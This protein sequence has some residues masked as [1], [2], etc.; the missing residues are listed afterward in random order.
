M[1][2]FSPRLEQVSDREQVKEGLM[3][4]HSLRVQPIH[5]EKSWQ[6]EREAA[7]HSASTGGKQREMSGWSQLTGSFHVDPSTRERCCPHSG[8]L[9]PPHLTAGNT[10]GCSEACSHGDLNPATVKE[11]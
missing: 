3:V 4:A 8:W 5:G 10:S 11:D 9:F 2:C 1:S 7:A 6:Q